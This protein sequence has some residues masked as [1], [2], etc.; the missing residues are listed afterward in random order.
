MTLRARLIVGLVAAWVV[1]ALTAGATFRS[2]RDQEFEAIDERLRS[3]PTEIPA[4]VEVPLLD[5]LLGTPPS[6]TPPT[7]ES[8]SPPALSGGL[9]PSPFGAEGLILAVVDD[10]GAVLVNVAGSAESTPSW[11]E[12]ETFR[13]SMPILS[14]VG[15]ENGA[16][17]YRVLSVEAPIPIGT[18]VV[19]ASLDEALSFERQLL[20][21]FVVLAAA[22][23]AVLGLVAYWMLAF[24]LRPMSAMTRTIEAIA[25]GERSERADAGDR[26]T[27]SQRLAAAFNT[28]LDERD[29]GE[30][31]LRAFVSNA[32]HELRTPLTS[33]NGYLELYEEGMLNDQS[34]LDDAVRRMRGESARMALLV[35]DLLLLARLDEQ[36][37]LSLDVVDV[38]ALLADTAATAEAG[39]PGRSVRVGR[40][41]DGADEGDD[42]GTSLLVIAD[43][44]RLQQAIIAIV[45][46]AMVHTSSDVELVATSDD[47]GVEVQVIDHGP[48]IPPGLEFEIFERFA[49]ADTSRTRDT[50]GSGLGLSVAKAIVEA[51]GG[52]LVA[53]PTPRGGA[54]FVIRLPS[55]GNLNAGTDGGDVLTENS[56][57][58]RLNYQSS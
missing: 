6:G 1:F 25:S 24:G 23:A 18:L 30:D 3:V 40:A 29:E 35:E 37:P 39:H 22:M 17:T 56:Q 9:T 13:T 4:G 34:E 45:N 27:E 46:N 43:G 38:I 33:I 15:S 47:P 28:M 7:S 20:I 26:R 50:G 8:D 49:R 10:E 41:G 2:L 16:S 42:E 21:R 12:V 14:T 19:G 44:M 5:A 57:S 32:S 31:R 54:T 51:H 52:S 11:S 55:G 53:T 36:Q 48:G 58:S